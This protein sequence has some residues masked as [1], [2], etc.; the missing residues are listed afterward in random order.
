MKKTL[1]TFLNISQSLVIIK[2]D[3]KPTSLA[4][5]KTC[6]MELSGREKLLYPKAAIKLTLGEPKEVEV[7]P[8]PKKEEAKV[9]PKVEPKKVTK[10]APASKAQDKEEIKQPTKAKGRKP[11]AAVKIETDEK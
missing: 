8:E 7:K 2:V 10:S 1:H 6:T 3:S 11:K 5:T 9:E 4:P